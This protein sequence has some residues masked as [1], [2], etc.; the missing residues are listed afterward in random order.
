MELSDSFFFLGEDFTCE[1][2]TVM[3]VFWCICCIF[4][5]GHFTELVCVSG[6]DDCLMPWHAISVKQKM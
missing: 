5:V 3:R 4:I 1:E 6:V 2:Y